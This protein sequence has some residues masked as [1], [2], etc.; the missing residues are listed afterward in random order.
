MEISL[1]QGDIDIIN[2]RLKEIE[3]LINQPVPPGVIKIKYC[4]NCA[5]KEFCYA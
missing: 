4:K 3:T 2:E 5:Y 1:S